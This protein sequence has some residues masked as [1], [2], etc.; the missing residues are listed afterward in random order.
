MQMKSM[1]NLVA[2]KLNTTVGEI[3]L[4][5][6]NEEGKSTKLS[7]SDGYLEKEVSIYD[8]LFVKI[9]ENSPDRDKI[10]T[11]AR[12]MVEAPIDKISPI[13]KFETVDD[14]MKVRHS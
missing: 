14:F 8:T 13:E 6:L 9:R 7:A 3:D 11:A 2:K 10:I 12:E 5:R 4:Y 1:K